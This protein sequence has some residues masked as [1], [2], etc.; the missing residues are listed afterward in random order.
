M[1]SVNKEKVNSDSA[2]SKLS[3]L[4]TTGDKLTGRAGLSFLIRY[5]DNIGLNPLLS[6]FFGLLARV[7]KERT[8][9][10]SSSK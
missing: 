5:I 7:A 10:L 3:C 1:L 4:G 9:N 6:K 8:W 2:T